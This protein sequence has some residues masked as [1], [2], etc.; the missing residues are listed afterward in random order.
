M[1]KQKIFQKYFS[2]DNLR[3]AWERIL[4]SNGKDIKD[5]FGIT[6]FST[7]IEKNL[8]RLSNAIINDEFQPQR[9]FK[10]YEPKATKTHRTK[11]VLQ[12]EDALIYQAIANTIATANYNKSNN[13]MEYLSFGRIL[14]RYCGFSARRVCRHC[15]RR[16]QR[17]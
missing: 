17:L 2:P 12:I 1:R 8:L 14:N 5:Y 16:L 10:Y 13:K 6:L 4:C 15:Q 3:L 11:T 7:N 9:P